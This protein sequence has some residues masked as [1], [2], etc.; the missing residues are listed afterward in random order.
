M[1]AAARPTSLAYLYRIAVEEAMLRE[2]LGAEYEGYAARAA[3]LI[4]GI[5]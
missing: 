4:P 2:R 1:V 5:Y 3:R